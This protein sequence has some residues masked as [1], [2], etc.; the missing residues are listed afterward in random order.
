MGYHGSVSTRLV[1]VDR[2][3]PMLL[4]PDLR[5]WIPEDDMVHL[6]SEAV[7]GMRLCKLRVHRRGSGVGAVSAE[8]VAGKSY[9]LLGHRSRVFKKGIPGR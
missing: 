2:Y 9:R 3:T 1:N 8:R 4:P 5:D 7:E 6:V